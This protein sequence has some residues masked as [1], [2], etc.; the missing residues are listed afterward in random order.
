MEVNV[1]KVSDDIIS[2][3]EERI[4]TMEIM[5]IGDLLMDI[6]IVQAMYDWNTLNELAD[7]LKKARVDIVFGDYPHTIQPIDIIESEDG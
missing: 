3:P 6:D 5:A 2:L 7:S 1:N 4:E